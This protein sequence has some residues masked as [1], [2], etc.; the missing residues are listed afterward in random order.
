MTGDFPPIS[1]LPVCI[2]AN[3]WSWEPY[4]G[5]SGLHADFWVG[6]DPTGYRWLLKM[7]G[8][9]YAY[10]ERTFAAMAQR[11]KLSCQSSVYVVL[12]PDAIPMQKTR[13][14]E[15]YQLAIWLLPEHASGPCRDDCP[16]PPLFRDLNNSD[17]DQAT[18]ISSSGIRHIEDWPKGE[19]LACLCGANECSDRLFTSSHC[20]VLIDS[21]Q[22]FSGRPTAIWAS[23]W[24]MD[25]WQKSSPAALRM[26]REVCSGFAGVTDEEIHQFST[27]PS[28]YVVD[29]GWDVRTRIIASRDAARALLDVLPKLPGAD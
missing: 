17:L 12:P 4:K 21:E 15:P 27:I 19:M 20:F 7:R 14:A 23:R 26:A 22:M 29:E 8:S 1:E 28:G 11:L 24:F 6:I 9:F 5:D 13:D 16:I 3:G 10:R 2:T 25:P 18:V